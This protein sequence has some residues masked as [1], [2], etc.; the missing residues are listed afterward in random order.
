MGMVP[1]VGTCNIF[2]KKVQPPPDKQVKLMI[3]ESALFL[4]DVVLIFA[5]CSNNKK[6][7]SYILVSYLM[8]AQ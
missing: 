6:Y 2:M 1:N 7:Y 8:M 3:K 4:I 5:I